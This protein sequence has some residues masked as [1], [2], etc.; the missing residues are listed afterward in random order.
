MLVAFIIEMIWSASA[1]PASS[2]DT[3]VISAPSQPAESKWRRG[4]SDA[5]RR[6][7]AGELTMTDMP[8]GTIG[9]TVG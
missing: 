3:S 5:V 1:S 2:S 9:S 7:T 4:S 8:W 6:K